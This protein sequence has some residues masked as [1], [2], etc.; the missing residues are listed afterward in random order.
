[1]SNI[2]FNY[3]SGPQ[4]AAVQAAGRVAVNWAFIAVPICLYS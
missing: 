1:M 4:F 2:Y 3:F